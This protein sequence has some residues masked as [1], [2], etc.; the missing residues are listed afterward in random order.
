MKGIYID[1]QLTNLNYLIKDYVTIIDDSSNDILLENI[2]E[3]IYL[4]G[5]YHTEYSSKKY[6]DIVIKLRYNISK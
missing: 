1:F 2:Y 5:I 6:N 4:D 3:G